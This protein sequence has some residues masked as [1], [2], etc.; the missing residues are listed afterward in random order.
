MLFVRH[1][2]VIVLCIGLTM[3][4]GSVHIINELSEIVHHY[5]HHNSFEHIG[6]LDFI[7]KHSSNTKHHHDPDHER[8]NMPLGHKHSTD[9][10]QILLFTISVVHDY[11][12]TPELYSSSKIIIQG[13]HYFQSD[14]TNSIWQPPK[15]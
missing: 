8:D 14:Y 4:Q 12:C 1:I 5:K 15:A 13:Q 7:T 10:P 3:P 9:A 6:W 11:S 2:I